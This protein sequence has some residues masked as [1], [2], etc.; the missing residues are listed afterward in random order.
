M[1]AFI[2]AISYHLPQNQLT[3]AELSALFPEW[4]VEKIASKIGI[5]TRH[6][7]AE[8][9]FASDMAIAAA[10]KLFAAHNI[11][12]TEIDFILYCT[13]SPD[14]FLPSTACIIQDKLSIPVKAGA[15]DF[16]LG[17]SGYVYGLALAKGLIAAGIA[18]N[19][20]LLTAETYS[21]FIHPKDKGNRT[22]FGDAAAATLISTEG[23][24]AIGN[25]E[26]G[27]DGKGAENLMVKQGAIRYPEKSAD[28]VHDDYGNEQSPGSL[29]MNGAEIFAFTSKEIPALIIDTLKKNGVRK[30]EIGQFILHQANRY[31]LEHLRKKMDIASENFYIYMAAVGN[32]VS[33]SVPIALDEAMKEKQVTPQTKWLL[34][35][36]GVG[37]SWAGTVITFI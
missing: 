17:C 34:A 30:D 8:D 16:N 19:I 2:K 9:E 23:F 15:L 21:K 28:T 24:A 27:T 25:F 33:S 14:Y 18:T 3:N 22:I 26:L 11:N 29:Y 32:T 1:Q 4:G 13:Q 7:A 35:G 36:F 6:I 31:M 20:L 12:P 37:Y 10:Q 5:S